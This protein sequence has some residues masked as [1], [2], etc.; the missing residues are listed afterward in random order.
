MVNT[1]PRQHIKSHC[2][3]STTSHLHLRLSSTH[4]QLH[5]QLQRLT[6]CL[7]FK[8]HFSLA[9]ITSLSLIPLVFANTCTVSSPTSGVYWYRVHA[10]SVASGDVPG[11]CGGLWDN[12]K[13]FADCIGVSDSTCVARDGGLEWDF[14]VGISCNFGMVVRISI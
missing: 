14:T 2:I 5:P 1:N 13:Q 9:A 4:S 6:H 12:L 3:H 10:D 11:R 7:L 8:M